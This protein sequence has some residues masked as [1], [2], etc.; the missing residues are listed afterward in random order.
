M[1]DTKIE[2]KGKKGFWIAEAFIEILSHYICK[3]FE[4]KDISA[5]PEGLKEIYEDC[6][7]NRSGASIGIVNISLDRY[8]TN[9]EDALL[10][11]EVLEDTKKIILAEGDEVSVKELNK[12]EDAK[13][14]ES[15]KIYWNTPVK[16]SSFVGTLDIM[17][18]MLKGEWESTNHGVWFKGF[19]HPKT[20]DPI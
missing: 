3:A 4:Q 8:I 17:Q 12:I 20:V 7:D 14:D 9:D 11:V 15:F 6:I 5:M 1:G 13:V 2:Y 19:G 18:K 10:L 16:T